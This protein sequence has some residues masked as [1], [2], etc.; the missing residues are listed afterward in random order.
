MLAHDMGF[1]GD[2]SAIRNGKL[3]DE[4]EL[5]SYLPKELAFNS[6]VVKDLATLKAALAANGPAILTLSGGGI[7]G[8]Y[9]IVDA[10]VGGNVTI[11]DPF[12][13]FCVD[14]DGAMLL[15]QM[16]QGRKGKILHVK[17]A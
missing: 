4:H 8:H 15:E 12:H 11:R 5:P 10:V 3:M 1:V 7:G 13:G 9:I 2:A 14:V 16:D 6:S 17:K